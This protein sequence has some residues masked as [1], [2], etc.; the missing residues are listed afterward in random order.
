MGHYTDENGA[1]ILKK[2]KQELKSVPLKFSFLRSDFFIFLRIR[3][4]HAISAA[5]NYKC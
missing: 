1:F 3:F 5:T 2:L 4:S